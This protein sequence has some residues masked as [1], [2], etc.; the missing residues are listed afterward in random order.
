MCVQSYQIF[1][2]IYIIKYAELLIKTKI[3]I[4][5]IQ[6]Y[7]KLNFLTEIIS[8]SYWV[9]ANSIIYLELFYSIMNFKL[10]MKIAS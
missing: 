5:F 2:E 7:F 3:N 6:A 8:W 10:K 9:L 1:T 4:Y